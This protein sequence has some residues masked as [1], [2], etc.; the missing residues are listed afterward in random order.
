MT[1]GI[2]TLICRPHPKHQD[3]SEKEA[4]EESCLGVTRVQSQVYQE[5]QQKGKRARLAVRFS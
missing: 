5:K 3:L 4:K 1:T 2:P